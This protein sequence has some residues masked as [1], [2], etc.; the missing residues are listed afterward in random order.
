MISS[1]TDFI[2][3]RDHTGVGNYYDPYAAQKIFDKFPELEIKIVKF[4][5][6]FFSKKL[7]RY[8]HGNGK[9]Q[10]DE[11]DKLSFISGS[12]ARTIFLKGECPPSWF[13]R[14]EISKIVLNAI[15]K[16]EQVFEVEEA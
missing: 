1:A 7:S 8:I 9:F 14:P 5:E 13:M 12:Q 11:S 3:G 16:G 6:I 4:K 2:I 15:K 10:Y